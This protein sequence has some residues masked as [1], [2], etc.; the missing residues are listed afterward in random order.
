M[1][2]SA[3]RWLVVAVAA[4]LLLGSAGFGIGRHYWTGRCGA[5]VQPL[6]STTS[7]LLGARQRA[8]RPDAH[9]DRLVRVLG[10]WGPPFGRVLGAAGYDYGQYLHVAALPGGLGVWTRDDPAMAF[11][12]DGSLRP[13][14]GVRTDTR[15]SAWDASPERF[16]DI[17]L[18]RHRAP[19]MSALSL[20]DGHS[21]WCARLGTSPVGPGAPLATQV[22]GDSPAGSRDRGGVVALTPGPPGEVVLSRL[23]AADGAV[24]WHRAVM[25]GGGDFLGDLGGGTLVAGGVPAWR[26]ADPSWLARQPDRTSLAGVSART[27]AL[28]WTWQSSAGSAVHVLGADPATGRVVVMSWGSGG[29]QV[30][31]LDRTGDLV[32]SVEPFA[33]FH[34]DATLRSAAGAGW[35]L[36][37]G[38]DRLAAYDEA[39]GRRLW[40]RRTPVQPQFFPYGFELDSVPFLDGSHVLLPTTT[41]VRSLDLDTGAMSSYPL[42]TDGVS[43]TYWPY[44]LAVTARE[45]AVVTN[46]GAV[47]LGLQPGHPR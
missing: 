25:A 43:T 47:V 42:P 12:P 3:R 26:L 14:W 29:A 40:Q 2:S 30:F 7:P 35:V 36:V 32:W 19:S 46:T 44:Q 39:T 4:V 21:L 13:R 9:R 45:V 10:R 31:A 6:A 18:P 22:L 28:R 11:L 38:H 23:A 5:R 8:T 34:L 27:G 15:S 33:G 24:R 20:A 41:A 1:S 37:R 17:A 16:L